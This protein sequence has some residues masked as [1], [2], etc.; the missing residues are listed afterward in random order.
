MQP[1]GEHW[2]DRAQCLG[3]PRFTQNDKPH[4]KVCLKLASICE[5][6][7]VLK[8]CQIMHEKPFTIGDETFD[9]SGVFVA[10]EWRD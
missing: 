8:D 10:G 5:G 2:V 3:D 9:V 1:G 4:E 7:P 6:C